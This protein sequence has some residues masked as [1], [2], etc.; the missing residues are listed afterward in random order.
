MRIS[1]ARLWLFP[2][3]EGPLLCAFP[4]TGTAKQM[5]R[6]LNGNRNNGVLFGFRGRRRRW[7]ARGQPLEQTIHYLALAVEFS[8]FKDYITVPVT[9]DFISIFIFKEKKTQPSNNNVSIW[10]GGSH[11][12]LVSAVFLFRFVSTSVHQG[13]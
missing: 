9:A 7:I 5:I 4:G 10:K 11:L 12:H 1:A 8:A 2:R 6:K 13:M 3:E